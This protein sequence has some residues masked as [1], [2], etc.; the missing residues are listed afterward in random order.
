MNDKQETAS[1]RLPQTAWLVAERSLFA[2]GRCYR[3]FPLT[4]VLLIGLVPLM[5]CLPVVTLWVSKHLIDAL[6]LY[7]ANGGA[8]AYLPS[9]L[10]ILALQLFVALSLVGLGEW[11]GYLSARLSRMV[12]FDFQQ[13]VWSKCIAMDY[14]HFGDPSVLNTFHRTQMQSA[15]ATSSLFSVI[16][17]LCRKLV[18]LVSSIAIL[19]LFSPLLCLV[20]AVIAV[21]SFIMNAKLA[22]DT[23]A[24]TINRT[25]RMRMQGYL[26]SMITGRLNARENLLYGLGRHFFEKSKRF[27]AL[28]IAE[29][30]GLQSRQNRIGLGV[31]TIGA[32]AHA[33]AYVYIAVLGARQGISLGSIMMN[34]GLFSNAQGQIRGLVQ[35][36]TAIY[37]NAIFLEDYTR[38]TKL[39]SEI[40]D[41][42]AG[43]E[44]D[45][46]IHTIRFENV[47]FTYPLSQRRAL[48]DVSF[49]IHS[50]ESI[51]LVGRNGAGK[52]TAIKLLLRLYDVDSGRILVNGRDIREYSIKNLRRGFSVLMQD[53]MTY[54]LS[55]R[56]NVVLGDIDN[57]ESEPAFQEAVRSAGL[58]EV[59]HSL[60]RNEET[61][62]G[63]LFGDGE[64]LSMGEWQR[65]GLARVLFRGPSAVILDEPTSALDAKMEE[66]ILKRFR[67]TM[68]GRI[69]I[70]VSHRFSSVRFSDRVV[71]FDSGKAVESG[72]HTQL[73]DSNGVY[74]DL[75]RVQQRR[76]STVTPS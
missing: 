36:L 14:W 66:E 48:D 71:V 2:L 23:Y 25:E 63:K 1:R 54:F 34:V 12:G 8:E 62:L 41:S 42:D 56:D 33:G 24:L 59:M 51:A 9:L 65:L 22:T 18:T 76:Y 29:D 74:A 58:T 38:F 37:R 49:E 67:E 68:D 7:L 21:P 57:A 20:A 72:T 61:T 45:S 70:V 10:R 17:A 46:E 52:S 44:L 27:H 40:E 30:M 60:P 4:T 16:L 13:E 19:F 64:D 35:D 69:A 73:M 32:L 31:G 53:F 75:F 26:S 15:N 11:N 28:T 6:T 50:G 39:R 47:T 3:S 5:G 55:F 43:V